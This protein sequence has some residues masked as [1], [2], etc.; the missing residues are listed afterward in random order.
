MPYW[1]YLWPG[2]SCWR[3]SLRESRGRPRRWFT[4]R[5]RPSRS[6]A[7]WAWRDWSRCRGGCT[8]ASAITT[9]HP[10]TSCSRA[11]GRTALIRGLHDA[12]PGLA[13]AARGDL[14]PDPGFGRPLRAAIG[15]AG[16]QP[17]CPDAPTRRPRAD[18]LSGPNLCRGLSR[19]PRLIRP[20][21]PDRADRSPVRGQPVD[22]RSALPRASE[23]AP[24]GDSFTG[25]A[26][27][28]R[29]CR[30]TEARDGETP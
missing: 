22:R 30:E 19:G 8:S 25:I 12:A 26:S 17:A 9:R 28:E 13:R 15:A 23:S 10:C 24:H 4:A 3:R 20:G 7:A 29:I 1:A 21:L 2:A 5:S 27:G 14:S 6:V 18:L 16:G 11:P